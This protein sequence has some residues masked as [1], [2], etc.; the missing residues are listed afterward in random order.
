[1]TN[2]IELHQTYELDVYPK[3]DIVIVKGKNAKVWDDKGDEYIDCAAGIGV[4]NV[5]HC[6]DKVVEAISRQAETLITL[7]GIFYNDRRAELLKKLVSLAPESITRVFLCNSG[8]EAMEAALKFTRFNTKKTEFICAMRGFHGRTM[9]SLSGTYKEAYRDGFGPLIEGFS[10]VPYNNF[11]KLESAVTSNT[12]GI[13]LELVQGEGGINIA[14]KEFISKVRKLCDDKGIM[15]IADEIQT[16]FCRTGR[17]F[18]CEH[19]DL[20]PDIMTVAKGIAGGFPVGAV[21][22]SDKISMPLGKHGTTF[23]G[24]PLACAAAIAAIDYMVENKLYEQAESKGKYFAEKLNQA[25][26]SKVREIR[27]LGLMIGIELKEKV[28][29]YLQELMKKKVLVLPAGLTVLRLLPPLTISK[30]ELDTVAEKLIEV[31]K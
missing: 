11:E 26:L 14:D 13:I 15:F 23:G 25:E 28:Q 8:T 22:C 27:H 16:G 6:N 24:N 7:P 3:R 5:G 19:Y 20:N 2:Y 4:A 31:L 12:A 9:G 21:L 17:F 18:A 1:M 29:P 10:F 30:E